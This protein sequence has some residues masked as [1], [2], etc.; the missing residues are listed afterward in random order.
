VA[1][2]LVEVVVE[3]GERLVQTLLIVVVELVET[4]LI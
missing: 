3:V 2:H 4:Q 1:T